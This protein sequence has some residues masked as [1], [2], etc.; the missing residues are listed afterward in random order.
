MLE[1]ENL[2]VLLDE[3]DSLVRSDGRFRHIGSVPTSLVSQFEQLQNHN[4]KTEAGLTYGRYA[5]A[6]KDIT[7]DLDV[8]PAE[9]FIWH[10]DALDSGYS[11]T[12]FS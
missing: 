7:D 2:D 9:L 3:L 6:V 1:I 8:L 12:N 11:D 5:R 4:A 10:R